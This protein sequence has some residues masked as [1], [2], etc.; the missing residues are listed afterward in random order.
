MSSR[1]IAPKVASS[2]ATTSTSFA[3]SRSSISMSNASMPANFLNRTALPSI[4]GFDA[5]AP[6][7][8]S[9]ST[10]GAVADHGH[11]V[12]AGGEVGGLDRVALDLE[13]GRATPGL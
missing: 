9:P 1:L 12:R 6:M 3:G 13:A 4:T 11:E 10:G 7:A 2:A 8:P 5:S